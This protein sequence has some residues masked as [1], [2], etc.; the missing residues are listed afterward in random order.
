MSNDDFQVE[1][2][3]AGQVRIRTDRPGERAV[4][5]TIDAKEAISQI[6]AAAGLQ[7]TIHHGELA[8]DEQLPPDAVVEQGEEEPHAAQLPAEPGQAE[9]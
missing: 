2:L 5:V 9:S 1:P 8:D 3:V 7:V 6:A 4:S